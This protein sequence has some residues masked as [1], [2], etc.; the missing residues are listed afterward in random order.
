MDEAHSVF[1][2]IRSM[3]GIGRC[4]ATQV[5]GICLEFWVGA[6]VAVGALK[7]KSLYDFK[8]SL[9]SAMGVPDSKGSKSKPKRKSGKGKGKSSKRGKRKRK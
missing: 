3:L 8:R 4:T 9:S 1:H 5:V 7:V 2:E 6:L